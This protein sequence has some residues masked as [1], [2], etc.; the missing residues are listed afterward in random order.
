MS[1]VP[2]SPLAAALARRAGSDAHA[3]GMADTVI[4]V[5]RELELALGPVIGPRGV[6]A[7]LDRSLHR[8]AGP[9]PWLAEARDVPGTEPDLQRLM[10]ALAA[11]PGDEIAAAGAEILQDLHDL[12]VSL[13][14]QTLT[15][16][17]VGGV[18]SALLG[19]PPLQD[20]T[21]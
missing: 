2:P 15:R 5:L 16:R 18:W 21:P 1:S 14:G 13:V 4:A 9:H 12:L 6:A 20:T 7:L 11:R 8:A 10:H 19:D 3:Q 17:L